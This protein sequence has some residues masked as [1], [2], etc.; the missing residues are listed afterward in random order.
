ML[1]RKGDI[2]TGKNSQYFITAMLT[3]ATHVK[4]LS[5]TISNGITIDNLLALRCLAKSLRCCL[6][7]VDV[8]EAQ[9]IIY[10]GYKTKVKHTN[11]N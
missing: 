4:T 7:F 1:D 8:L 10:N 11:I 5:M 3:G 9:N 6:V 2:I